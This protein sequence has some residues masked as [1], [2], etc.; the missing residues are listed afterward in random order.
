M[1]KKEVAD[2]GICIDEICGKIPIMKIV[3]VLQMVLKFDHELHMH[4]GVV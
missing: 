2:D 3:L 4:I 1:V